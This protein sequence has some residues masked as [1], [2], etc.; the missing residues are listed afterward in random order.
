M[1]TAINEFYVEVETETGREMKCVRP[2]SF[3]E[4]YAKVEHKLAGKGSV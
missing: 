2:G 3:S 4:I 1:L